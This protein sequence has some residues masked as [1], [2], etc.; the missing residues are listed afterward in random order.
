MINT[1]CDEHAIIF[2]EADNEDLLY[3]QSMVLFN[4]Y[5]SI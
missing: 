3:H 1:S 5:L 2:L 4:M